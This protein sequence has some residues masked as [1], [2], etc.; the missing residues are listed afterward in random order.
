MLIQAEPIVKAPLAA[1]IQK[2][3]I[4]VEE[5]VV[6]LRKDISRNGDIV[7]FARKGQVMAVEK[8]TEHWVKVRANDTLVGWVPAT[9]VSASGPPVVWDPETVKTSFLICAGLGM[10]V[11]LFLLASLER[12]RRRVSQARARQGIADA[13]R[14]LQNKIHVL[15]RTEPRIH[16]RLAMDEVDLMDYLQSIGYVATLEKDPENFLA[17]CKMSKPNL[18]LTGFEFQSQVEKDMK[19]EAVLINTPVVYLHCETI[20]VSP[21]NQIRAYLERHATDK[22]LGDAISL[23]LKKSPDKIR[24]SIKQSAL[25][26][27]IYSGTLI[28]LFHF[29]ASVKKTGQLVVTSGKNKADVLFLLGN[30]TKAKSQDLT[31]AVAVEAILDL[32]SGTFEFHEKDP[33]ADGNAGLNTERVLMDWARNRDESNHHPRA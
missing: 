24:H 29:I 9:S 20:P 15:F 7:G 11:F 6:P 16:S 2:I 22:E 30:I 3:W 10:G 21:K 14:R 33:V 28:E 4:Q 13:K 8:S 12:K 25:K 23:C 31:G 17:S 32:A 18:V 26:G 19:T 5:T 27:A 1:D